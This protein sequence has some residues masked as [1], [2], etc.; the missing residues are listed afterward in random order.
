MLPAHC[1]LEEHQSE[2]RERIPSQYQ[3]LCNE[4][5]FCSSNLIEAV[6]AE[7]AVSIVSITITHIQLHNEVHSKG[8]HSTRLYITQPTGG[9]SQTR[10]THT[11]VQGYR[12]S[13]SNGGRVTGSDPPILKNI[14]HS[15]SIIY[16]CIAHVCTISSI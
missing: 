11:T 16:V 15:H 5:S 7:R 1:S 13:V 12:V 2:V 8:D 3:A 14:C 4:V 10:E 6:F 9:S